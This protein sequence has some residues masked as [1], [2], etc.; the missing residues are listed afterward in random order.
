[1]SWEQILQATRTLAP[2]MTLQMTPP[3]QSMGGVGTWRITSTDSVAPEKR[4]DMLLDAYSGQSLYYAGWDKQTAFSKATA[5][6]IPFHRGEF[7]WWNQAL[8]LVFGLGVL[9]S[10]VSGWVMY[11]KRR[12]L[13]LQGLPR[14]TPGAWRAT[15]VGA[16]V[17]AALL[18]VALPLLAWSAAAVA[19]I[20]GAMVWRARARARIVAA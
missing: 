2:A 4:F 8:L 9:S 17:A 13:G 5:I 20:E 3:R 1:M 7:G 14:L 16:L 10:L 15:P 12:A 18:C 6:G 19:M 11:F